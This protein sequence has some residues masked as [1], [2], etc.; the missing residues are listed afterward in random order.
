[1]NAYLWRVTGLRFDGRNVPTKKLIAWASRAITFEEVERDF[2]AEAAEE[3][4]VSENRARAEFAVENAIK[5][6]KAAGKDKDGTFAAALKKARDALAAIEPYVFRPV[7]RSNLNCSFALN[8]SR[9][10]VFM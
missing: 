3:A 10:T 6:K 7:K 1:M 5:A 8:L 4:K 9:G 2:D